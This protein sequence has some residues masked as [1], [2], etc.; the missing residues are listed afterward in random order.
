MNHPSLVHVMDGLPPFTVLD[1]N[2]DEVALIND[3]QD[4]LN[5]ASLVSVENLRLQ[6]RKLKICISLEADDFMLMLKRYG[7][8]MYPVFLGTCPLFKALREV[9]CALRD[10]SREA[11]KFMTLST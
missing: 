1:L 2:E 7:N 4:L 3:D 6:R 11:R 10:Y 5:T 9:I 8:L